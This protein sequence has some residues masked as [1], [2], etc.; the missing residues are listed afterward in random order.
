MPQHSTVSSVK[1]SLHCFLSWTMELSVIVNKCGSHMHLLGWRVWQGLVCT[2]K[3]LPQTSRVW[4]RCFLRWS[5]LWSFSAGF[6]A[7]ASLLRWRSLSSWMWT[8]LREAAS[9]LFSCNCLPLLVFLLFSC[10]CLPL[11]VFLLLFN[12][13]RIFK[14]C[15]V[16][17][18][19][20]METAWGLR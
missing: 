7:L 19:F 1:E 17:S 20:Y 18:L 14:F 11:L 9:L 6:L 4:E 8:S 3:S 5:V 12:L 10:N 2:R 16:S 13:W 15:T